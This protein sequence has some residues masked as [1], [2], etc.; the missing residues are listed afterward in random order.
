MDKVFN[1]E[2][3]GQITLPD[4]RKLGPLYETTV[5]VVQ[6]SVSWPDDLP[7][8]SAGGYGYT[9][10]EESETANH[11]IDEKYLPE[12]GR[13]PSDLPKPSV[14]G[15]GY[16][17]AGV[18]TTVKTNHGTVSEDGRALIIDE[19]EGETGA[20]HDWH[21]GDIL[22]VT[23][24]GK[25][26]RVPFR[27]DGYGSW[28]AGAARN[29]DDHFNIDWSEYDFIVHVSWDDDFYE[30]TS[31]IFQHAGTYDVSMTVINE[32]VHKIDEKYLP[33]IPAAP[34]DD[35]TYTLTCTVTDGVPVYS[36]ES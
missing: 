13:W 35:S 5:N 29:E 27:D 19:S 36:W 12:S 6:P 25:T 30:Y 4:G 10:I 8:P 22:T 15:Y 11:Q 9:T 18:P 33:V 21:V 7:V 16:S 32:T 26:Y 31:V 14:G 3:D 20:P 28:E 34:S 1:V 24:N 23:I 2:I 17:S